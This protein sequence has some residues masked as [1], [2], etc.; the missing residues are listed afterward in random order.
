MTRYFTLLRPKHWIKSFFLFAAPF[1]GGR[2][3][4]GEM[5]ITAVPAFAAFSLCASSAYIFNDL[6]DIENDKLHP[7]KGKRPIVSGAIGKGEA[8]IIATLLA[9]SSFAIAFRIAPTFFSFVLAYFLVQIAYSFYLKHIAIVDIFCIASG[10][11]IRVLAGG[12]AFHVGVSRWLLLTMFMIS[13]VLATGKRIA[14]VALLQDHVAG[15]RRSLNTYS[16][17]V[18]NE[19][20]V[21]S[22]SSSLVSY[23]LYTIEQF[24]DLIY[25]VPIVTF[26]LFRYIM[27]SRNHLGDPTEA[28]TR[29][30]W[31]ALTVLVWLA[32]VGAIRY[33]R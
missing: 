3:F 27:L 16:I 6:S 14:E 29:D 28:M 25:T 30:K 7:E 15:H 23:A 4:T 18:L 9:A 10:F 12:A 26:G 2:L 32:L 24:Q 21:I 5:L 11:V 17:S 8:F 22:A 1:F 19:I 31:L 20:M 13:L 33:T